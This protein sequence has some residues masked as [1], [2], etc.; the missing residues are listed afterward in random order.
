MG[1]KVDREGMRVT[2][3]TW[4]F[5]PKKRKRSLSFS[6]SGASGD[7]LPL[8]RTVLFSCARHPPLRPNFFLLSTSIDRLSFRPL[9]FIC[10]FLSSHFILSFSLSLFFS[11]PPVLRSGDGNCNLSTSSSA[12]NCLY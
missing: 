7:C 4:L 10:L 1:A 9:P 5:G 11:F 8:R 12:R 2:S 3:G 6:K